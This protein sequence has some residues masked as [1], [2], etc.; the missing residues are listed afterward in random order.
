MSPAEQ[1]WN[2]FGVMNIKITVVE[3]EVGVERGQE[4]DMFCE[5]R[6]RIINCL[7]RHLDRFMSIRANLNLIQREVS[8]KHCEKEDVLE[9]A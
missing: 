2:V 4:L 1:A 9:V 8:E 3:M 7:R 5:D 6:C